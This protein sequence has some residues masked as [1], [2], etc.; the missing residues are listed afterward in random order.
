MSANPNTVVHAPED[1]GYGEPERQPRE[2][3]RGG[4]KAEPGVA[5]GMVCSDGGGINRVIHTAQPMEGPATSRDLFEVF[6]RV[7]AQIYRF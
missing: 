4:N 5:K 3:P 6:D 7:L 2:Q 1:Y